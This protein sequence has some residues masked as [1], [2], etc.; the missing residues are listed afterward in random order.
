[1]PAEDFEPTVFD[2]VI[3]G[4][5]PAGCVLANRLSADPGTTVLLLEA[6]GPD[7]AREIRIPAAFSKLFATPY[8]WNYRTVKQPRLADRELFWPR[9]KTLGGSTSINAQMWIRGCAADY[10]GW[11]VDGWSYAEVLPYFQKIERRVGAAEGS[12]YG[13]GGPLWIDE[14]RSPS[15]I[16][17]AFLE[18]CV[19]EGIPATADLNGPDNSGCS[20]TPV[21]QHRGARFSAADAYLR[22]ARRRPNLTVRTGA[23]VDRL[24]LAEPAKSAP[25][26]SGPATSGTQAEAAKRRVIGVS[27]RDGSGVVSEVTAQREVLLCAGAVNT[28]QILQLSGIGD[29]DALRAAGVEPVHELPG[30]G[31]NL[32]DHLSTGVVVTCPQPIT[33]FAAESLGSVARYLFGRR[34]MLSSNVAEAVAFIAPDAGTPP[35]IE[36]IFAPVPFVEHGMVPPPA[37]GLTIGVVLLQPRSRGTVGIAGPTAAEPPV[38]EPGYLSDE[39]D[40]RRLIWGVRVAERLARSSALAPYVGE[41]MEPYTG[42]LDDDGLAESIR[43]H[44]ETLYHPVG[45]CRMGTDDS[46]VVDASLRVRGLAGVRVV[47]ASVLPVINR[48]HTMAPVYMVAE[49]AADLIIA[50]R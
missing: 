25:A 6:G 29:P 34:G 40:L 36:L 14:L 38:I 3:V 33:M 2:Y 23:T 12:G 19:A 15:R 24:R 9:G 43:Q 7:K 26:K 39:A 16:T 5:G 41:P 8:D 44:S 17:A 1:M 13:T 49:K 37:H 35:E 50:G 32:Q 47:D 48:G 45:T 11:G 22:P 42:V 31:A 10:D 21:T 30:V 4:A 20:P 46:A 28:P 18:A 27:Y